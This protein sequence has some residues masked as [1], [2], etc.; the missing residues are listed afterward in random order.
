MP[1]KILIVEDEPLLAMDLESHVEGLGQKVVGIAQDSSE[2][3][4][5]AKSASPELAF[6]DVNL[7]DGRTGP[8]IAAELAEKHK[9]VVVF[10]TASSE[11]IPPDCS[12][13]LGIIPKPWKPDTI[14]HW[15][16]FARARCRSEPPPSLSPPC[17]Q[18]ASSFE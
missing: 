15:I 1:L 8:R 3:M 14:E 10:V 11:Q 16:S 13:A 4:A 9:V 18:G 2:A 6:V 17:M 12:G 7:R 5:L